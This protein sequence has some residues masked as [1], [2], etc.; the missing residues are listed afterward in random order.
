[1]KLIITP[2]VIHQINGLNTS[3]LYSLKKINKKVKNNITSGRPAQ[4]CEKD[5]NNIKIKPKINA[6]NKERPPSL[7][8]LSKIIRKLS[9]SP[10]VWKLSSQVLS[11]QLINRPPILFQSN[12]FSA[13]RREAF[14]ILSN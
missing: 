9:K 5:T 8:D 12:S 10:K 4:P 13:N 2:V 1:M 14:P 3:P 6:T 11:K 7:P